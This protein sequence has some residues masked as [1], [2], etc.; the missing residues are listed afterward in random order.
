MASRSHCRLRRVKGKQSV[1]HRPNIFTNT[2]APS[3]Y[4]RTFHS[5]YIYRYIYTCR[6]GLLCMVQDKIA[7]NNHMLPLTKNVF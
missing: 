1:Y 6:S 3:Q 4:S 2:G 7:E 5:V